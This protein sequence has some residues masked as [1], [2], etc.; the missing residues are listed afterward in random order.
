[1]VKIDRFQLFV[2]KFEEAVR[3]FEKELKKWFS[4]VTVRAVDCPDLSSKPFQVAATGLCGNTKTIQVGG[5]MNLL[6]LYNDDKVSCELTSVT[7][8]Y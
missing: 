1:M 2:P 8:V 6:P 4:K 7:D 5:T 3:V